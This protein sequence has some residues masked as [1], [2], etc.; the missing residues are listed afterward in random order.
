[1]QN[2]FIVMGSF[3]LV[4]GCSNLDLSTQQ[5]KTVKQTEES[6]QPP[7]QQNATKSKIE[8]KKDVQPK[9]SQDPLALPAMYFN[10]IKQVDGKN[11]IQNP[12]NL[13]VLVNK[14]YYLPDQYIPADLVRPNVAFSFGDQKLEQSLLRKEAALALETMFAEAK[15]AGIELYAVSGY[16]SYNRQRT[17]FDA[18]VN[19]VGKEK[20]EQA[21]AVP[22][23]SEHQSGLAMDIGSKSTNFYL[24]EGFSDTKEGKWLAENAH[25]FGFILRYPKGKEMITHYEFEAWHFRYVGIKP[26]TIMYEHQWTLEEYFQEVKKI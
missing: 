1:M 22:G 17:L 12:D 26:A 21:V 13:L 9:S 15:K 14:D 3:F 16:R 11:R 20:A 7:S 24:T 6:K 2:L 8:E 18:E 5:Q 19:K 23:S 10:E 25:R 4:A